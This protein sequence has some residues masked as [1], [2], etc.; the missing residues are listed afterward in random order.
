MAV[1]QDVEPQSTGRRVLQSLDLLA[2]ELR[3][4]PALLTDEVVVVRPPLCDLVQGLSGSEMTGGGDAGLLEQLHGAIDRGQADG[5]MFSPGRRQQIFQRHVTG[6]AKKG[7]H[8]G[9]ALLRGLE[10]LAFQIRAPV[11]LGLVARSRRNSTQASYCHL[12]C[13]FLE[14]PMERSRLRW[15]RRQ[16]SAESLS[17]RPGFPCAH[18][19]AGTLAA[20]RLETRHAPRCLVRASGPG[21]VRGNPH[22]A[23]RAGGAPGGRKPPARREPARLRGR[24][25]ALPA[26]DGHP[27]R[28]REEGR[29]AAR[30]RRGGAAARTAPFDRPDGCQR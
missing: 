13:R 19:G 5:G 21:T 4:E 16:S 1:P 29:D 8:D 3:D 15:P 10:P 9:L 7:V 20:I 26:R 2:L 23:A 14:N 27:R 6:R 22:P 18:D 17:P 11:P 30:R 25:G 12:D 24:H 28:R